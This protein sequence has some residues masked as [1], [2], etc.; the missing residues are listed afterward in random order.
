MW[1]ASSTD[2]PSGT[3]GFTLIEALVALAVFAIAS[4]I[5]YRGLDAVASTKSALDR[6]IRF[7]R[8]LGLVFDRMETDVGQSVPRPLQVAPTKLASPLRGS[9][10]VGNGFFVE[11]VR[12]DGN[13]SPVRV[14]YRCDQGELRLVLTPL[15]SSAML[16]ESASAPLSTLLLSS[17]ERCELAFL[18]PANAWLTDWPGDQ[19]ITRPRAIRVRLTL[20]GRG[21]FERLFNLP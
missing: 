1:R 10:A 6:E 19:S 9:S 13:R 7:W 21:D 16:L 11:L 4:V 14:L 17:V 12:H 15:N 8:E 5:A 3:D 18:N 20:S 2:Y